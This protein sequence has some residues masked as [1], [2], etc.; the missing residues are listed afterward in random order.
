[1]KPVGS[2]SQWMV[3]GVGLA[4]MLFVSSAQAAPVEGKAVVRTVRGTAEFSEQGGAW[5][6]LRVGKVLGSGSAV[7]AG[8]GSQIDLFLGE[9]GPVVRVTSDTSLE[10][11]TLTL[12]RTGVDVVIVTDLDLKTGTILG[13]VKKMAAASR[14]EV[15]TPHTVCAIRGTEYQISADG[16]HHVIT[17]S[18]MVAYT[19]PSTRQMVTQVVNEGQTFIP[20]ATP[21]TPG[22]VP[23]VVQ[24]STLAP[25]GPVSPPAVPPPVDPGDAFG[26]PITI[27]PEPVLVIS[28][29]TGAE[30]GATATV[31]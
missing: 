27:V 29:G 11:D 30:V 6:P 23:Q 2:F 24:T 20:P 1:M 4:A 31:Q 10:L 26:A 28:P 18:L 9:N 17:G 3:C 13:N 5:K 22:A 7:R 15:K 12:D 21:E 14:Y 25:G 19:N 8:V 16:V